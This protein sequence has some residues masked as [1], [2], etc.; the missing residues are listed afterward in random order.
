[1]SSQSQGGFGPTVTMSQP[2]A[3]AFGDRKKAKKTA[4]KKSGFR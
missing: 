1:M 4:K 2:I 3:G